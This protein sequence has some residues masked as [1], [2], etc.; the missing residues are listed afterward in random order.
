MNDKVKLDLSQ[1]LVMKGIL[2]V[3]KDTITVAREHKQD[4]IDISDLELVYWGCI[5][6]YELHEKVLKKFEI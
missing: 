4:Y 6:K 3:L 2:E 5:K 1:S